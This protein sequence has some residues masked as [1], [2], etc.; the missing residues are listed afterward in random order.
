MIDTQLSALWA[1]LKVKPASSLDEVQLAQ[2]LSRTL[3]DQELPVGSVEKL[4]ELKPRERRSAVISQAI[5]SQA[6]ARKWASQF[7]AHWLG[8]GSLPRDNAA[9]KRLE[10]FVASGIA[11]DLPWNDVVAKA[12]AGEDAGWRCFRQRFCGRRKSSNGS[13]LERFVFGRNACVRP[14]S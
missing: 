8:G 6:F 3:T 11:S 4:A 13:T 7:V 5:D 1:R 9:V 10:E 14:L 12:I 2:S